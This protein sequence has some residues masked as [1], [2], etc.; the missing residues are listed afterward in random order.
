VVVL[1]VVADVRRRVVQLA[2]RVAEQLDDGSAM[3]PHL[4]VL[5]VLRGD[6]AGEA[7]L[8]LDVHVQSLH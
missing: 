6:L 8:S 4:V 7:V 3:L 2:T 5:G 1:G